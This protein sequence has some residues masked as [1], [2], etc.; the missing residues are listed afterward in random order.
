MRIVIAA[1]PKA[2]NAWLRCLLREVYGLANLSGPGLPPRADAA[3]FA[4]WAA[5]G[6]FPD[7]ALFHQH[8]PYSDELADAVA[9][10]PAH[11]VTILRDPYDMFVSLYHFVQTQAAKEKRAGR[12]RDAERGRPRRADAMVGRPLGDPAVLAFLADGFG[13]SLALGVDWL[14]SGRS[15]VVRYEDLHRD[16][17]AALARLTDAI[18]PA[19]AER[20][21]RAVEACRA[22]NQRR[23][24][25][26]RANR[27]RT[28]TVGDS[29]NHLGDAHLALFRDRHAAAIRALG[30]D[31]R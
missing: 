26:G 6:R 19:P 14:R 8:V 10:L 3:S 27:V 29:K 31:V 4:E 24:K 30:Y 13:K 7:G 5:A 28:A 11:L 12:A 22:D 2:G 18:A 9:A 17:V 1:P 20:V 21:A 25:G 23:A 15:L 16:P